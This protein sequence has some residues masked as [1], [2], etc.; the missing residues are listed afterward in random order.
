MGLTKEQVVKALREL[1][2]EKPPFSLVASI[3]N[4]INE[5]ESYPKRTKKEIS[6]E[7]TIRA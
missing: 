3:M 7:I 1:P 6:E 2:Q 4:R 5:L